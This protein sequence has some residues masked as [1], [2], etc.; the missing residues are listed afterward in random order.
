MPKRSSPSVFF[1]V[2]HP[3]QAKRIR[4]RLEEEALAEALAVVANGS[5][6]RAKL[7]FDY[8]T[9]AL[10]L[11]Q[12][13]EKKKNG[14]WWSLSHSFR[15]SISATGQQDPN[16]IELG[17]L[18]GG[19]ESDLEDDNTARFDT[20]VN[21]ALLAPAIPPSAVPLHIEEA[22][23]A[24]LKDYSIEL[25]V[26]LVQQG[27]V[28]SQK[29]IDSYLANTATFSTLS[30]DAQGT[31]PNAV[32][33]NELIHNIANRNLTLRMFQSRLESLLM[34]IKD[35]ICNKDELT[36]WEA[37]WV[38]QQLAEV[39]RT[40]AKF[41]DYAKQLNIRLTLSADASNL[42]KKLWEKRIEKI[43]ALD[44]FDDLAK[45]R[46]MALDILSEAESYG[47][48]V[49]LDAIKIQAIKNVSSLEGL[50]KLIS[51]DIVRYNWFCEQQLSLIVNK[52]ELD[53]LEFQHLAKWGACYATSRALIA[54]NKHGLL[55][56]EGGVVRLVASAVEPAT[57][58][59]KAA[60]LALDEK[61][62]EFTERKNAALI[63]SGTAKNDHTQQE[64]GLDDEGNLLAGHVLKLVECGSSNFEWE[65]RQALTTV[66]TE[67]ADAQALIKRACKLEG[68]SD[69]TDEQPLPDDTTMLCKELAQARKEFMQAEAELQQDLAFLPK[70]LAE[71]TES[72]V[73]NT[74][75]NT[76]AAVKRECE[77][78]SVNKA[79]QAQL[80]TQ[81]VTAVHHTLKAVA[82][83]SFVFNL[84]RS[85]S[86]LTNSVFRLRKPVDKIPFDAKGS[87]ACVEISVKK[88]DGQERACAYLQSPRK[89][90]LQKNFMEAWGLTHVQDVKIID[91]AGH[92]VPREVW[93]ANEALEAVQEIKNT[94]GLN[95]TQHIVVQIMQVTNNGK[96]VDSWACGYIDKQNPQ[97]FC[98]FEGELLSR[99][100]D[101]LKKGNSLR[102]A[103]Q[104]LKS[105]IGKINDNTVQF[106]QWNQPRIV[107]P[108]LS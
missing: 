43:S 70:K 11:L 56:V 60:R 5:Y 96:T 64:C 91:T 83:D 36:E 35:M 22:L 63:S 3:H 31:L 98:Y 57:H 4:H 52:L 97:T 88:V 75:L 2:A 34:Q 15:H 12:A 44:T 49:A 29:N 54:A 55:S 23:K 106:N 46:Q 26:A 61:Q 7:G 74:A 76:L 16:K 51:K 79:T 99:F 41:E 62:R 58:A 33:A 94:L 53:Q 20:D 14:H 85:V 59:I 66:K 27:S 28:N 87:Y 104:L 84:M 32:V 48:D 9:A 19:A 17:N 82:D 81:Q 30:Q 80:Y 18:R 40:L 25:I 38:E 45:A 107:A 77:L 42:H 86:T 50:I 72:G 68:F 8:D 37:W 89:G 69:S 21:T 1:S 108:K 100:N 71:T 65:L 73:D 102:E 92:E 47:F 95:D 24:Q 90:E 10:G 105:V 103:N 78:V 39:L 93:K 6:G 101:W 67:Q 13:Y